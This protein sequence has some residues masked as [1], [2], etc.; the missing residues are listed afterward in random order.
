MSRSLRKS[1]IESESGIESLAQSSRERGT[2]Y[3]VCVGGGG[4]VL[5]LHHGSRSTSSHA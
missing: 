5:V 1:R 3:V 2:Q 4:D